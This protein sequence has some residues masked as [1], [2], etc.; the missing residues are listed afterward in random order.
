M[1]VST[2]NR[3]HPF[4]TLWI[5]FLRVSLAVLLGIPIP[6]FIAFL[7]ALNVLSAIKHANLR[8][9]AVRTGACCG[10]CPCR[11]ETGRSRQNRRWAGPAPRNKIPEVAFSLRFAIILLREEHFRVG[12]RS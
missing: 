5:T 9:P 12:G 4:E 1:D 3:V 6:V 11:S 2:A 8:M 7:V 10:F